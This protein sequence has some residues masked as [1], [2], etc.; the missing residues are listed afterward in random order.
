MNYNT[1]FDSFNSFYKP[2]GSQTD[3]FFL[4]SQC[5]VNK[6]HKLHDSFFLKQDLL[7]LIADLTQEHLIWNLGYQIKE[8]S[9]QQNLRTDLLI[10]IHGIPNEE[11]TVD[12][13]SL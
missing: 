11:R 13:K 1:S 4:V 7:I 9:K 10:I 5:R 6:E 2:L 8:I 12:L 3:L